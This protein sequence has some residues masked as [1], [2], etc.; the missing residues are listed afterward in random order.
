MSRKDFDKCKQE[1]AE[2]KQEDNDFDISCVFRLID[3]YNLTNDELNLLI[4]LADGNSNMEICSDVY[5]KSELEELYDK[6]NVLIIRKKRIYKEDLNRR[7]YNLSNSYPYSFKYRE[8]TSNTHSW[9]NLLYDLVEYLNYVYSVD[10]RELLNFKVQWSKQNI[11]TA[12]ERTNS[13][14]LSNGLYLNCNHTSIHSC[15]LIQDLIEFYGIRADEVEL[16]VHKSWESEPKEV[17]K[18]I[19][20]EFKENFTSFIVKN[21]SKSYNKAEQIIK[22]IEISMNPKLR[23]ISQTYSNFFLF[24]DYAIL[25]NCISKFKQIIESNNK[26]PE[27]NKLIYN[28]Y[29]SYL[30]EYYKTN[31]Y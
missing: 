13:K 9:V 10:L 16:Y 17:V 12:D 7:D 28:R 30:S 15:W 19:E 20:E 3:K 27:K 25:T 6:Y 26:I 18:L 22:N 23:D 14:M 21:H 11:F 24:D 5:A 1:I 31:G 29:L 4:E 2:I 8:F